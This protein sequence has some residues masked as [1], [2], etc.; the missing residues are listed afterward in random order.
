M[1]SIS[2]VWRS[3]LGGRISEIALEIVG[4]DAR[5]LD[6]KDN[7]D[8][9]NDIGSTRNADKAYTDNVTDSN[10]EAHADREVDASYVGD[11]IS[12]IMG[13]QRLDWRLKAWALTS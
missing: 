8:N 2:K 3:Y 1:I 7:T 11:R 10:K 5:I 12:E 9:T 13:S 4:M 6:N